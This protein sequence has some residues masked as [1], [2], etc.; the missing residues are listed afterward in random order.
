MTTRLAFV[1][2][3]CVVLAF[4]SAGLLGSLAILAQEPV[5]GSPGQTIYRARCAS[6]AWT[7]TFAGA[8]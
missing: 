4:G 6:V 8:T 5:L 3:R 7:R 2:L 1:V